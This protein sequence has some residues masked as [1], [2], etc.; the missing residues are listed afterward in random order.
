[1]SSKEINTQIHSDPNLGLPP[2]HEIDMVL[3]KWARPVRPDLLTH[4]LLSLSWPERRRF[5]IN[6]NKGISLYQHLRGYAH[7][8]CRSKEQ[9]HR[10]PGH[11]HR[12]RD[13]AHD[14]QWAG[15]REPGQDSH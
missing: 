1:M 14:G 11:H 6:R 2:L 8:R 10:R 3:K 4:S 9:R 7:E 12:R 5:H 15:A 13:P